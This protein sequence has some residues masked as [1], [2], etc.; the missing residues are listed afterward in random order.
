MISGA[1]PFIT[2]DTLREHY[3]YG[4]VAVP[5]EQLVRMHSSS[6]TTGRA[7]VIFHTAR[8]IH[9]WAGLVARCMYMTGVRPGDV[10]QNMMG[11]GLFTG[12][13][14]F[15]YGAEK[16]GAMVIPAGAGNS[17]RQIMLMQEF[18]TTVIHIIPSYG[19]HLVETFRSYGH[20]SA[21]RPEA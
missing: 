18:D 1:F 10:F 8:D 11:Y 3:P 12:G 20:R 6:G 19:L 15:H 9:E 4:F 21:K 17:K 2:K 7:T 14:G 16:L 5:R 13:L